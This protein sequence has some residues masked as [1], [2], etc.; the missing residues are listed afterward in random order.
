MH[1]PGVRDVAFGE[2]GCECLVESKHVYSR[3]AAGRRRAF[4]LNHAGGFLLQF[5]ALIVGS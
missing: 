4:P 2:G 5:F 3:F 1:S